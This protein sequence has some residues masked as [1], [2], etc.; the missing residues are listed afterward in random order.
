MSVFHVYQILVS[1]KEGQEFLDLFLNEESCAM[2]I[3]EKNK[4]YIH[5]L[6][7]PLQGLVT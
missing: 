5:F 6:C 7:L 3:S 4:L 1:P 2:A